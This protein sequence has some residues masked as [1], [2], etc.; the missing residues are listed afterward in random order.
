MVS[1]MD[2]L[3]K[4]QAAFSA[5]SAGFSSDGYT[6]ADAED[7][8]WMLAGLPL[9]K[10]IEALDIA[11]G[12]GE[13]ARALAPQVASVVGVDATGAMLERA[14][15]FVRQHNIRN[16]TFQRAAVEELP[17]GD[18]SFDL[19]TC[20]YAF[21]HFADP[22]PVISEM[23]RVC[24]PGG[25]ILIV[26]LV[27]RNEA[28]ATQANYHEWLCDQSHSRVIGF[29]EFQTL[30][31]LFGLEL[32]SAKTE[33]IEGPVKKWMDFSMTQKPHSEALLRALSDELKGVGET[34]LEPFE[35]DA[36]LHFRQREAAIVGRKPGRLE[37]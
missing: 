35:K 3:E 21:H 5:Q 13:L 4:N 31:R 2:K 20:R 18:E 26:D 14:R 16:I 6:Y 1:K 29:E 28:T 30:F 17:F 23:V 10:E 37:E 25:H 9:T 34:G 8:E 19:V 36:I 11:T 32:V 33:D 7:L 22:K 15:S 24:R 27:F 12:T